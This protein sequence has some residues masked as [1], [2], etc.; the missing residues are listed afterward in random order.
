MLALRSAYVTIKTMDLGLRSQKQN[1]FTI[2]E[3]LIVIVVIAILAAISIVAFTGIQ[4]RAENAKTIQAT[5]AWVKAL[6][7]YKTDHGNYPTYHSC[8]GEIDTYSG[9]HSGRCW[10]A[11]D[12]PLWYVNANFLGQMSEHLQTYP[13]PS[14]RNVNEGGG[15]EQFRGAMYYRHSVGDERV[16]VHLLNESTCPTIS[17]LGSSF[18]GA[19][20]TSGRSCYYK[21]PQ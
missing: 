11:A 12:N 1:G 3:L 14:Q 7:L 15:A 18:G 9:S 16:Y 21:L 13:V 8:L 2:I 20:R 5:A 6:Q 4:A 17:G 10:G 19:N